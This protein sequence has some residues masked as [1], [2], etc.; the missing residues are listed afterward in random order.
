MSLFERRFPS[1]TDIRICDLT[2]IIGGWENE[3]YSFTMGYEEAGERRREDLILR[4][5]PGNDAPQK[6]AR[7]FNVMEQLD[8]I[9]FP[10]P[11]VL[12]LG[13][14][15][16]PFDK[17]L[18]VMEKIDGRLLSSVFFESPEE[19]R[20]ELMTVFC[21][22][23]V[24]LHSLDWRPFA[25]FIHVD[26]SISEGTDPYAFIDHK[27]SRMRRGVDRFRK[28]GFGA[29]LDWL[30][31]RRSVVTCARLSLTHGDYHPKNVLLRSDGAPFIIDWGGADIADF[32]SDL[33]W[34]LLLM[35]TYVDPEIREVVLG[36]YKRIAGQRIEQIE[37]FEVMAIFRRLFDISVSL[38]E[39]ASEMGMRPGAEEM[40]K[41]NVDHIKRVHTLLQERTGITI[42]EIEALLSTLT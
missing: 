32:R 27:L 4:I 30:E 2:G 9:G 37:Y 24:D 15:D 33:A 8:E 3:V 10:V 14:N 12:L 28:A 7:E 6:S 13:L 31:E 11:R 41:Q 40:M 38:T 39:G 34:T 19:R 16:S 36:E 22:V 21:R 29:I 1:R 17:P 35:S 23:F 20:G 42:S 5:Y 26:P 18:V 25:K